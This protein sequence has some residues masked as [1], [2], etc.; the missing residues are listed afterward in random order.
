ML[1][2]YVNYVLSLETGDVT[3]FPKVYTSFRNASEDLNNTI[4]EYMKE[5]KVDTF[6]IVS[7]DD[8]NPKVIKNDGT[9]PG[10]YYF[11]KKTS[12]AWIY[13]KVLV[14]GRLWNGNKLEKIGKI[15]VLPEINI[16]I[17]STMVRLVNAVGK[18]HSENTTSE[19][20]ILNDTKNTNIFSDLNSTNEKITSEELNSETPKTF[21]S[22]EYYETEKTGKPSNYE[23]GNHVSFIQELKSKIQSKSLLKKV[24]KPTTNIFPSSVIHSEFINSIFDAKKNLSHVTPP[25][26]PDYGLGRVID[27]PVLNNL[28]SDNSY[29]LK[30][31]LEESENNNDFDNDSFDNDF[32]LDNDL[33]NDL[34]SDFDFDCNKKI[35]IDKVVTV[36]TKNLDDS[37]LDS[38]ED[39]VEESTE[40]ETLENTVKIYDSRNGKWEKYV[41][42]NETTSDNNE[43]D[44]SDNNDN[45]IDNNDNEIDNSD[46][47]NEIDNSDDEN[48]IDN[49]LNEFFRDYIYNSKTEEYI[50]YI[51]DNDLDFDLDYDFDDDL[52]YDFDDDLD[53]DYDDS[54]EDNDSICESEIPYMTFEEYKNLELREPKF[55]SDS[56]QKKYLN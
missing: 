9:N 10:H 41:C 39:Q 26:S 29:K 27:I 1:N 52:D 33:D 38:S 37:E 46:N 5:K 51:V 20:T 19:K 55:V 43:I 31:I 13:K 49:T 47:D 56:D 15:G 40:S 42:D 4:G 35:I 28:N 53:Y 24:D 45:E 17:D 21:G 23:H 2:V 54:F 30:Y 44:N 18:N 6:T 7:K 11:K 34:D 8:F 14:E 22:N 12:N 48:I 36:I 3:I 25:P 16:P 50:K 32:D